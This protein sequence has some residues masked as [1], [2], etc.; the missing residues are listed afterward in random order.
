MS[1]LSLGRVRVDADALAVGLAEVAPRPARCD[2]PFGEA[3]VRLLAERGLTLGATA[4]KAGLS[5]AYLRA[6]AAGERPAPPPGLIEAVAAALSVPAERARR[7]RLSFGRAPLGEAVRRLLANA[8][9]TQRALA[10]RVGMPES[11]VSRV[12]NGRR[13]A[14]P[15]LL[16]TLA[17]EL[18]VPPE[19]FLE[20][21]LA[22]VA[23]WLEEES[24]RVDE[25]FEGEPDVP[26]LEAP[27]QADYLERCVRAARTGGGR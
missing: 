18:A 2:E 1:Q 13:R 27:A 5:A 4:G 3:L 17:A 7:P 11:E 24:E 6:L 14:S 25:L 12:L 19:H 20:Y 9:M 23:E 15:A 22:V 26:E 21:R 8:G 16:E 10:E